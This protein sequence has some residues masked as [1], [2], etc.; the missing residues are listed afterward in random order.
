M[1]NE[2][3]AGT[4]N[5]ASALSESLLV[6][7]LVCAQNALRQLLDGKNPALYGS[8]HL[9]GAIVSFRAFFR[10]HRREF[11]HDKSNTS[12]VALTFEIEMCPFWISNNWSSIFICRFIDSPYH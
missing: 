2:L 5:R 1:P 4:L 11:P 10:S 9:Q 8:Y 7:K 3:R 6:A 12:V